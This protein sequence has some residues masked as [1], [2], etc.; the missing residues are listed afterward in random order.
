MTED[1]YASI[2]K[3]MDE[4]WEEAASGMSWTETMFD[5]KWLDQYHTQE[6]Q[7]DGE[8]E[9]AKSD[10]G[11]KSTPYPVNVEAKPAESPESVSPPVGEA[12]SATEVAAPIPQETAEKQ[13]A[14]VP[15]PDT[16][17]ASDVAAPEGDPVTA[18]AVEPPEPPSVPVPP[19][20]PL[21]SVGEIP[22]PSSVPVPSEGRVEARDVPL[23]AEGELPEPAFQSAPDPPEQWALSDWQ[24][25]ESR[26]VDEPDAEFDKALAEIGNAPIQQTDMA[27]P[28]GDGLQYDQMA[29]MSA[30]AIL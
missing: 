7:L 3:I 30:R 2:R 29:G 9:S 25:P 23:P 13:S 21:E 28:Y 20:T 27:V 1:V 22:E 15:V 10:D 5:H 16:P 8:K 11:E 26:P 17:S 6:I 24:P 12:V 18:S 14:D 19:Q 4:Q